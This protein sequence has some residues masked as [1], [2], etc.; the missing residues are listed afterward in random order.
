MDLKRRMT[1]YVGVFLITFLGLSYFSR[2]YNNY[3]FV[4]SNHRTV[5][6][7]N[8]T[9]QKI[10][11]IKKGGSIGNELFGYKYINGIIFPNV[12]T[13][14]Y[15]VNVLNSV[16]EVEE[17]TF[18]KVIEPLKKH[19]SYDIK[20]EE[21]KNIIFLNIFTAIFVIYNGV[22]VFLLRKDFFKRTELIFPTVLL[23]IKILVTNTSVF[24]NAIVMKTNVIV[25]S[26]LG[27]YL[28]LYVKKRVGNIKTKKTNIF[29]WI[30]FLM[31]FI[32]E[33]L[34][35]SIILNGN[36]L[37]Y[38]TSHMKSIVKFATYFYVWMDAPIII[39]VLYL[40]ESNMERKNKIVKKIVVKKNLTIISL[41]VL[42]LI[43]DF[44]VFSNKFYFYLNMFEFTFLYWYIF[45]TDINI[46]KKYKIL[47]IKIFQMFIHLYLFFVF[48]E[49]IGIVIGIILSFL[50]LNIHTY[51][52]SGALKIDKNYT[53]SLLNRMYLTRNILEFQ[54]QLSKELKKNL[55]LLSVKTEILTY[56]DD[57]KK[58][59]KERMYNESDIL[60][61]SDDLLDKK[62][63]NYA[64]R[65]RYGKKPFIAVVLIKSCS[66]KLVYEEKR[67]LEE[68]SEKLSLVVSRY[69]MLKLQE[70]LNCGK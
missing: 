14:E 8:R 60:L 59:L 55:D 37:M 4:S 20:K 10:E 53:E 36:I 2:N 7:F 21:L 26:L 15:L 64:L 23:F 65:L 67:Y 28:L 50:I 12:D 33:V 62:S 27:L 56:E 51:I 18:N 40:I 34:F 29:L 39:L 38:L 25:T 6:F 24:S 22:L 46:N 61:D 49:S 5:D 52:F 66:D 41:L 54:E 3:I 69:R 13:G 45:L 16:G 68:V 48:T 42:S 43:V 19:F 31:Y 35:D 57:Y 32:P 58:Y 17:Y 47:S 63:Y 1:I 30:L 11:V 44:L 70:E 9:P